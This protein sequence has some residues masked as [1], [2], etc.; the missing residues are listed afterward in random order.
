MIHQ[1][2]QQFT[3][4][5]LGSHS[6]PI[7]FNANTHLPIAY[8]KQI[9]KGMVIWLGASWKFLLFEHNQLFPWLCNKMGA[10]EAVI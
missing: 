7:A 9:D 10:E 8:Y 1:I 2:N 4:S 5:G 6:I 3:C